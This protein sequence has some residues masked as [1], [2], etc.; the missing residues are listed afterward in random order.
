MVAPEVSALVRAL[1]AAAA[2]VL[3]TGT[4]VTGSGPHGGDENAARLPFFV[5]DVARVHGVTVVL[6]LAGTLLLAWLVRR[7]GAPAAVHG[8][9]H[10]LLAAIGAQAVVGYVQYFT[11]VPPLLVGVHVAG[12]TLVWWATLSLLLSLRA[13][14]PAAMAAPAAPMSVPQ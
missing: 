1:V 5:P 8:R 13:P 14:A 6:F 10:A 11:D 4:V 7:T 12:A 3:V 2:L 9:V